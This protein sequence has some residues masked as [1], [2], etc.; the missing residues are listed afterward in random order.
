MILKRMVNQ[1][2]TKIRVFRVRFRAP[3][4]PS[5]AMKSLIVDAFYTPK[6][7]YVLKGTWPT[8][9]QKKTKN[10]KNRKDQWHHIEKTQ[11][12][13][14][15]LWNRRSVANWRSNLKTT[16]ILA[17]LRASLDFPADGIPFHLLNSSKRPFV[18]ASR[19]GKRIC[20]FTSPVWPQKKIWRFE[21]LHRFHRVLHGGG[22]EGAAILHLFCC[23]SRD[24]VS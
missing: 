5:M 1:R 24:H 6:K 2:G 22:T 19:Q 17:I 8:S 3:S 7:H 18:E 21:R 13:Q 15:V 4:L 14:K 20:G 16:H 11:K 9:K 10:K 12:M 23:S